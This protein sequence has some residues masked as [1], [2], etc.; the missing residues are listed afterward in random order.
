MVGS[1]NGKSAPA[2]AESPAPQ[3]AQ[4]TTPSSQPQPAEEQPAEEEKTTTEPQTP[5]NE[6]TP[7]WEKYNDM[8]PRT[9]SGY[10]YITGLDR[11]EKAKAG[12][13]SA[14]IS[15]RVFGA[16]ELACYIEVFNGIDGRTVLEEG[17]EVKIPKIEPKK[18]VKKRLEQQ[19][20]QQ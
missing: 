13:T 18:T 15:R 9:K 16:V 19:N 6:A 2:V 10:Y 5:E 20:N 4:T 11:T 3:V 14:R 8:D 12:D 1:G 17:T 7:I